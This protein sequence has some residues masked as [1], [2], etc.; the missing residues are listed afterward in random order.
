[1]RLRISIGYRHSRIV[2][3]LLDIS[4]MA[5]HYCPTL[6]CHRVFRV[7][8]DT[9]VGEDFRSPFPLDGGRLGWG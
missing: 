7:K 3:R 4:K 6:V 2:I 9:F 8:F 1:M 5:M